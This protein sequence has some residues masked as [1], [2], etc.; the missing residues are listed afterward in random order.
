LSAVCAGAAGRRIG[1][2]HEEGHQFLQLSRLP[3]HLFCR[4]GQ[5]FG[6]TGVLLRDL[7]DLAHGGVDLA[8]SSPR[9]S[10]ISSASSPEPE[11]SL[12]RPR[13]DA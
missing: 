3:A 7:V 1:I 11:S 12:S 13:T 10:V 6:R 2:H 9:K 4:D 5:F 8:H